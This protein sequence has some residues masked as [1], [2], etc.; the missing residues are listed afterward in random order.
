MEVAYHRE[1]HLKKHREL[2]LD[3]FDVRPSRHE[4]TGVLEARDHGQLD[5]A[6]AQME[7]DEIYQHF[8]DFIWRLRHDHWNL[9]VDHEAFRKFQAGESHTLEVHGLLAP[10]IFEPFASVTLMGANLSDSIMYKYFAKEGCT[11]PDHTAINNG[12]RYRS[13]GNGSRL[14][15]KYLT[16]RKVVEDPPQSENPQ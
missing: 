2:L 7:D 1:F 10:S 14:L 15:I 6:L 5:E 8:A 3:L 12:L 4:R 11:F 9:Y 16:E 13:H